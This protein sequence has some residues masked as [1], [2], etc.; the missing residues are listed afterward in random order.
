MYAAPVTT[1]FC[2]ALFTTTRTYR[3]SGLMMSMAKIS[4]SSSSAMVMSVLNRSAKLLLSVDVASLVLVT[5]LPVM[6]PK[7]AMKMTLSKPFMSRAVEFWS[8]VPAATASMTR[9]TLPALERL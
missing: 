8:D 7:L 4:S 1:A 6:T 5:A 2:V 9:V 3:F